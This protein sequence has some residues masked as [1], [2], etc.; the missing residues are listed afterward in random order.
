MKISRRRFIA[1]TA[2]GVGAVL[3][4]SGFASGKGLTTGYFSMA[5][6]SDPLYALTWDS[7][8]PYITTNFVFRDGDGSAIDLQLTKMADTMPRG[9]KPTVKGEECFSLTFSGSLR[10]PLVQ[11]VYSVEH[12]ALGNFS[13]MITVVGQARKSF[14]YE[15]VI[16]RI[17]G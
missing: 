4:F 9:Y 12:F 1:A 2:L 3:P 13:L 11:D 5:D 7:F 14:I 17:A 15:A 8:Y 10:R 16:N 6:G